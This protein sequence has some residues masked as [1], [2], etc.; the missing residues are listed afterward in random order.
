MMKHN[1][2][3]EDADMFVRL[4]RLFSLI[5]ISSSFRKK[6][7][8]DVP[9][10]KENFFSLWGNSVRQRESL[11]LLRGSWG[12][13]WSS[14]LVSQSSRS[15]YWLE[16]HFFPPGLSTC[17]GLGG[18]NT[19]YSLSGL[20]PLNVSI[21]LGFF[22]HVNVIYFTVPREMGWAWA[23][24]VVHLTVMTHHDPHSEVRV[25]GI[26]EWFHPENFLGENSWLQPVWS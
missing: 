8:S 12:R 4:L 3:L 13:T 9:S 25:E 21:I 26:G 5:E 1:G 17:T 24:W 16:I 7:L 15:P 2:F 6:T 14:P 23:Q 22:P 10:V 11:L 20:I 19:P 18:G